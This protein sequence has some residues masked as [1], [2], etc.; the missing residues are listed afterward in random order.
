MRISK[1]DE[2]TYSNIQPINKKG[3]SHF[4]SNIN[5]YSNLPPY[6]GLDHPDLLGKLIFKFILFK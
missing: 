3:S 4:Y 5:T 6:S 2:V 1:S